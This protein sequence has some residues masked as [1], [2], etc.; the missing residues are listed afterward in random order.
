MFRRK[1]M[2]D[3]LLD[4]G[5]LK[6]D[7]K[8]QFTLSNGDKANNRLD[9]DV[10]W[11]RPKALGKVLQGLGGLAA[12]SDVM[13]GVPDGGRKLAGK[14]NDSGDLRASMS[15]IEKVPSLEPTKKRFDY[16]TSD[17]KRLVEE[18]SRVLIIDDEI[19]SLGSV[20]GILELIG[21]FEPN[22]KKEVEVAAIWDRRNPRA[23]WRIGGIVV[24][25]LVEE[26][27]PLNL[28]SE[29]EHADL[30]R[31]AVSVESRSI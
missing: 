23:P 30:W 12:K 25:S 17:S 22:F 4:A 20:M 16:S 19:Y 10:L 7:E 2:R 26:F 11:K 15:L 27:I 18:A 13:I 3:T 9:M 6:R 5:V 14:L 8:A 24:N 28:Q 31:R 21:F 29:G 1:S